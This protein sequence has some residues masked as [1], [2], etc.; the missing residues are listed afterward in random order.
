MLLQSVIVPHRRVVIDKKT[1]LEF[2]FGG[3][4]SNMYLFEKFSG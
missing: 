1:N 3:I 2:G 4:R